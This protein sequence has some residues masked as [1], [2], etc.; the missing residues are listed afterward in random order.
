MCF[1]N[2]EIKADKESQEIHDR[3]QLKNIIIIDDIKLIITIIDDLK[4]NLFI[5]LKVTAI[6]LRGS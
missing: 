5:N 2:S 3:H 1:H 4:I 6:I